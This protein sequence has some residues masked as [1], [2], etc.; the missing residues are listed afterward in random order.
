M[1]EALVFAAVVVAF[2][3]AFPRAANGCAGVI[4]FGFLVPLMFFGCGV[5][6]YTALGVVAWLTG[7]SW[8]VPY[9]ACCLVF[10]A[11]PAWFV[12]SVIYSK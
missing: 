2:Q 8:H 7:A 4:T 3:L 10:G 11:P 9:W 1:I 5:I 6:G 12:Y